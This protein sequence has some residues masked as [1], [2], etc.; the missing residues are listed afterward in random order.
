MSLRAEAGAARASRVLQG[1][2]ATQTP[3]IDR[4]SA[5]LR[6][7]SHGAF[8]ARRGTTMSTA[9]DRRR[10][11]GVRVATPRS[12]ADR[13]VL[14]LHGGGY[15]Y[16]SPALYR[17]LTWRIAD[18]AAATRACASTT[19][20]RP[21]IRFRPRWTTRSAPTA[22]CWRK[23]P[24][25]AASRS[26]GTRRAAGLRFA[27]LLRLRDERAPLPAAAVALSPWTDLTLTSRIDPAL[28]CHR[29]DARRQRG[30]A[31][32]PHGIWAA[33]IRGIPMR[34]RCSA[35]AAAC[36]RALIHAGDDEMLRDDAV[37]MAERLR[38]AGGAAELEV[39]P[40]MPHVWQY[41]GARRTRGTPGDRRDRRL[42]AKQ[43][44]RSP[45][46]DTLPCP[47]CF[48]ASALKLVDP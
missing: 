12:R 4:N 11:A 3:D 27:A 34:R 14:Y 32:S 26:W 33:P 17:D 37:T 15:V 7:N 41:A 25:R 10:R 20:S 5:K 36:R 19:G 29:S 46:Y 6:N 48:A 38:A 23:A 44:G 39:W 22:G 9:V 2:A 16:G 8:P 21:S 45:G 42:S 35:I 24:I 18:A 47:A 40:R 43:T 28:R 30:P 13:H 1:P 31:V